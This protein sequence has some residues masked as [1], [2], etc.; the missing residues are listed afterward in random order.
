M[1]FA[2]GGVYQPLAGAHWSTYPGHD[3]IDLNVGSGSADYGMPIRAFRAGHISYA[4]AGRGYGNAVFESGPWGTVVYG[5]MSRFATRTGA[6]VAGGQ[7]LGYV[8]STGNSSG[9]HLHF[10]FPGGTPAQALALLAGA[11][12]IH[13]GAKVANPGEEKKASF[14][15]AIKSIPNLAKSVWSNIKAL[16]GKFGEWGTEFKNAG[17]GALRG[18]VNY[19]DG[20]IPNKIK[21]NNFPD[22]DLP[23]TPI[24]SI[25]KKLGIFD[26]GGVLEPGK[27]AYNASNKP[28]AVF[29]QRQFKSFAQS[30]GNRNAFPR[31]VTLNVEG[32]RFRAYVE[33]VARDEMDEE[34]AYSNSVRRMS[35]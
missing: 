18:A 25:M 15:D 13:G 21:V 7:V 11:K 34:H 33:G 4:G 26:N 8:G 9:P 2:R 5:H 29:N 35:R 10:G 1:A 17:K 22:L 16:P 32:E 6:D 31:E 3:G 30:A 20:K 24:M 27:F 12:S 23:D 14:M 19:G 28:E